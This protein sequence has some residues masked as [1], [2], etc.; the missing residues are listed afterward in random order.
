[1]MSA[2]AQGGGDADEYEGVSAELLYEP[3]EGESGLFRDGVDV[4]Y[5]IKIEGDASAVEDIDLYTGRHRSRDEVIEHVDS[6][7]DYDDLLDDDVLMDDE[8]YARVRNDDSGPRIEYSDGSVESLEVLEDGEM[9][10][11]F[12]MDDIGFDAP[13]RYALRT[14]VRYEDGSVESTGWR[15]TA[16]VSEFGLEEAYKTFDGAWNEALKETESWDNDAGRWNPETRGPRGYAGALEKV[17]TPDERDF[18]DRSLNF[19]SSMIDHAAGEYFSDMVR[20]KLRGFR[21]R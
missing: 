3:V 5:A 7:G 10:Y 17:R 16:L 21:S 19:A 14:D 13:G 1:M 2:T 11:F 4:P 6:S 20:E 9:T 8:L 18:A 15:D 12:G